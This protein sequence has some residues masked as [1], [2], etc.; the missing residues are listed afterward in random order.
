MGTNL[1]TDADIE[2]IKGEVL[3]SMARQLAKLPRAE[4]AAEA[5]RLSNVGKALF[6][7]RY[8]TRDPVRHA[9]IVIEQRRN[10][11]HNSVIRSAL[12]ENLRATYGI[13]V[14]DLIYLVAN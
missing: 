6:E 8:D 1:L 2:T 13:A 14:H 7:E 5:Q 12:R 4:L 3:L 10:D 11:L 9:E